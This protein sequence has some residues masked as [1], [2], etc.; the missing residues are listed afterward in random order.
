MDKQN[1]LRLSQGNRLPYEKPEVILLRV[2]TE[3]EHILGAC[4]TAGT[5]SYSPTNLAVCSICVN[6]GS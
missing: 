5:A 4:K 6:E 2:R 3:G 1:L